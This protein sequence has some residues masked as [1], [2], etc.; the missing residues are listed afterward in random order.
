MK[1]IAVVT[2]AAIIVL[3]SAPATWAQPVSQPPQEPPPAAEAPAHVSTGW[4][5]LFK[6]ESHPG[7]VHASVMSSA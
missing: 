7:G 6:V 2:F 1:R 4:S 3:A 5:A